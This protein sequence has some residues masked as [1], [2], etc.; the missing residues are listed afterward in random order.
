MY[1]YM[2]IIHVYAYVYVYL[3]IYSLKSA[4]DNSVIILLEKD[5]TKQLYLVLKVPCQ[6]TDNF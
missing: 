5:N 3:Y 1:I 4:Q 2:Y 6:R